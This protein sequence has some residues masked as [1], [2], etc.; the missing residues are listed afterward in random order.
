MGEDAR[1]GN[2]KRRAFI[3][4]GV[5]VFAVQAKQARDAYDEKDPPP[6]RPPPRDPPSPP[7]TFGNKPIEGVGTAVAAFFG[8]LRAPGIGRGTRG[9]DLKRWAVIGLGVAVFV[10]RA[11]Q[12]RDVY[13]EEVSSGNKP[14]EG[15]GTAVAA[16][17]G[18]LPTRK[19]E[20]PIEEAP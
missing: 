7:P 2:L 3:S 17:V 5:A 19:S 9:G 15:V 8:L 11:T 13:V 1:G 6:K 20:S 18:L 4:L 16:F 14:I 12:A 10:V